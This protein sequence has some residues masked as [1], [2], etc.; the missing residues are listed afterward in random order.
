MISAQAL[1]A[2]SKIGGIELGADKPITVEFYQPPSVGASSLA[3][4]S[5]GAGG[6]AG[7][8]RTA[9]M[10]ALGA[11]AGV[12]PPPLQAAP[13]P[14]AA[15]PPLQGPPTPAFVISNMFDPATETAPKW[16]DEI[17]AEV[18]AECAKFGRVAHVRARAEIT[19]ARGR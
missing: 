11:R 13:P 7:V 8:D 18:A 3:L 4:D 12:A 1:K 16:Q 6:I 17:E 10:G 2:S 15:P 9:L 5:M 19:V 14:P